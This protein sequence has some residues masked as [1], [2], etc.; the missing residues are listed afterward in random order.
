M[1]SDE[2][3]KLDEYESALE[4]AAANQ[5]IPKIPLDKSFSL[6]RIIPENGVWY[7]AAKCEECR[8]IVPLTPDPFSGQNQQPLTDAGGEFEATC[9]ACQSVILAKGDDIFAYQWIG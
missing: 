1:P 5:P 8:T 2:L 6:S 4:A 9:H 7:W 3:K